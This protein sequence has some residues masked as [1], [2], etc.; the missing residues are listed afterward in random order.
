MDNKIINHVTKK[1][2]E[3]KEEDYRIKIASST[4]QYL[5]ITNEDSFYDKHVNYYLYDIQKNTYVPLSLPFKNGV[6][7]SLY[8]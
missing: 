7:I 4:S 5:L 3:I 1:S 6:D 8:S 2:C